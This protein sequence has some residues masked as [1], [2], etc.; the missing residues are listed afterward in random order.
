MHPDAPIHDGQ[1]VYTA[2]AFAPIAAGAPGQ[3][4]TTAYRVKLT[5][6]GAVLTSQPGAPN[7]RATLPQLRRHYHATPAAALDALR[8]RLD[9]DADTISRK[10]DA[11][12]ALLADLEN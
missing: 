2:S 5:P 6:G 3:A 12:R 11:I 9:A 4:T 8:D 1:I 10:I 7:N